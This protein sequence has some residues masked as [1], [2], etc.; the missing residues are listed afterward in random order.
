MSDWDMNEGENQYSPSQFSSVICS[1]P[2]DEHWDVCSTI[3][4]MVSSLSLA[5]S[6]VIL[7]TIDGWIL[8]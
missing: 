8:Q 1:L 5:Y 4:K 2:L 7:P 6:I 3:I